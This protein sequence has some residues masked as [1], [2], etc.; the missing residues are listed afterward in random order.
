MTVS[1]KYPTVEKSLIDSL[2]ESL[3]FEFERVGETNT[4]VC[5][6][7]LP[8]GF[9]VGHGDS[10]CADLRNYDF[11]EGCYWAKENAIADA[12]QTLWQVEVYLLKV[13]GHTSD[14][15][16]NV[17]T[18][19]RDIAPGASDVG[20]SW[21]EYKGRQI[22]RTAYE[23]KDSDKI[24][25][26]SATYTGGPSK[27]SIEIDGE[28]FD[29]VHYEPAKPGDFICYLDATDIYHVRRSVMQQ[30]NFL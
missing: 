23:I 6:A 19:Q 30:R 3:V 24:V 11:D 13:T 29:F 22:N 5:Y 15:I 20:P 10:A 14:T 25:S 2:V 16:L 1:K 17:M 12:K 4:T 27:S 18:S 21:R 8:N 7:F 28:M 26:K 9:R